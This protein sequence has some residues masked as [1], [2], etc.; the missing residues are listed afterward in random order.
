MHRAHF[1]EGELEAQGL[2]ASGCRV[3]AGRG[4][5]IWGVAGRG[6]NKVGQEVSVDPGPGRLSASVGKG[7]ELCSNMWVQRG[8]RNFG[9][10]T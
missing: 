5:C 7:G 8:R 6:H 4:G 1:V 10:T 9:P 3:M 2:V